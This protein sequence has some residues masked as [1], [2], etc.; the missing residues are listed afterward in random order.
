MTIRDEMIA[1]GI[2]RPGNGEYVRPT[3]L[4]TL[5]RVTPLHGSYGPIFS[6]DDEGRRAAARAIA[7]AEKSAEMFVHRDETLG[8]FLKRRR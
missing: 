1:A 8:D 3:R 6:T 2:L 5:D 7:A 4:G